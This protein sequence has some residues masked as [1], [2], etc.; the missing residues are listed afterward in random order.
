MEGFD[1]LPER[2]KNE[3][4]LGSTEPDLLDNLPPALRTQVEDIL[5]R[6]GMLVSSPYLEE[7]RRPLIARVNYAIGQN[8]TSL[9]EF[10]S[11]IQHVKQA[12]SR[13]AVGET[14]VRRFHTETQTGSE[15]YRKP[16]FSEEH[17]MS[18]K[19]LQPDMIRPL[20]RRTLDVKVGYNDNSIN[21]SQLD[22]YASLVATSQAE[23]NA[24]LKEYLLDLGI[25]DGVLQGHD[26]VFMPDGESKALE[27]ATRALKKIRQRQLETAVAIYYIDRSS[28]D[29]Q[30]GGVY[31][32][33]VIANRVVS[34]Y[35]G[36]K[37]PD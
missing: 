34:N 36:E 11:I 13:G 22:R 37:L 30:S 18:D 29:D 32:L 3:W 19:S 9:A 1:T 14:F 28:P 35:V 4:V 27:A 16:Y 15:K 10:V 21:L 12:P 25:K 33:Q 24:T 20:S 8:V 6:E 5:S 2:E 7:V 23:A 17:T 26:Y 31:S